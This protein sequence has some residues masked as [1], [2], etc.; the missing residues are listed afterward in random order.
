MELFDQQASPSP[1]AP[2]MAT[3]PLLASPKSFLVF[4][5]CDIVGAKRGDNRLLD[6]LPYL[7]PLIT[8]LLLRS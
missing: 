7:K 2:N 8:A 6:F 5:A 3:P 4:V 1:G